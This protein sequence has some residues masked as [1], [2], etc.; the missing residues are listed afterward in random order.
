MFIHY[1][2]Q[3]GRIQVDLFPKSCPSLNFVL[4]TSMRS[5]KLNRA[6]PPMWYFVKFPHPLPPLSGA[7]GVH[8]G[9]FMINQFTNLWPFH[10]PMSLLAKAIHRVLM[11]SDPSVRA[12]AVNA[13][14]GSK[15][16]NYWSLHLQQW[17]GYFGDNSVA[18]GLWASRRRV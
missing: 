1:K 3:K 8:P 16:I 12:M 11:I 15:T 2:N 9:H 13:P 6:N 4:R 14:P 17:S 7:S 10:Y 18:S 5:F